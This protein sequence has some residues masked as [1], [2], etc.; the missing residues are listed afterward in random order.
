MAMMLRSRR[1]F[2]SVL[3]LSFTWILA[4]ALQAQQS[5]ASPP[6][7]DSQ[8]ATPA[9]APG[10]ETDPLNRQPSDKERYK[11]QRQLRQE[12]KGPYKTWL[13]EEVPYIISDDERKAFM[14]LANDEERESFIENFWQR[15]NPN[16]DSPENEFREEHY[17]RIQYANDHYAAGKP[18]W[19]TDRGRIYIM[20][21]PADSIDAHP[22]GGHV[23]AAHGRRRRRDVDLSF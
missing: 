11:E 3:G 21:G 9:S 17:R 12:L 14:S 18:G 13:D 1:L 6:A 7:S 19:K 20:W 23:R 16:P 8:S 15:R 5:S 22:A 2:I 4:S 10:Q